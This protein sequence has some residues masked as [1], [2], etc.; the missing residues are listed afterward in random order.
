MRLSSFF[1]KIASEYTVSIICCG[2]IKWI[3]RYLYMTEM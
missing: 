2:V 3:L 1:A